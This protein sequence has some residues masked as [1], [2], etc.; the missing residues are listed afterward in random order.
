VGHEAAQEDFASEATA[1]VTPHGACVNCG[2]QV[3]LR[4]VATD[5]THH[6]YQWVPENEPTRPGKQCSEAAMPAFHWAHDA[7]AAVYRVS[8]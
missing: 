1:I 7:T 2:R 3:T 5:Q 4:R 6:I 8:P